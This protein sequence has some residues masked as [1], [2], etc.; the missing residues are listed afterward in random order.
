MDVALG[1]LAG[2]ALQEGRHLLHL[3]LRARPPAAGRPTGEIVAGGVKG[4]LELDPRAV[5][6][7]RFFGHREQRLSPRQLTDPRTAGESTVNPAA[8]TT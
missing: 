2:E 6:R 4:Q 7:Y 8:Q 3:G 5:R 1:Q